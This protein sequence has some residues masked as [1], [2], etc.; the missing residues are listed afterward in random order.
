MGS[1]KSLCNCMHDWFSK[2]FK[3]ATWLNHS[4]LSLLSAPVRHQILRKMEMFTVRPRRTF[5]TK[6]CYWSNRK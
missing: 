6:A 1:G 5:A 2:L 4:Q 3:V